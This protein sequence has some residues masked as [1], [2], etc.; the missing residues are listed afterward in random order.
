LANEP[1]REIAYAPALADARVEDGG[2]PSR[3]R[4]DKKQSV[5]LFD[6]SN[7]GVEEIGCPSPGRIERGTVLPAIEIG[8][9]EAGQQILE[10]KDLLHCGE[11]ADDRANALR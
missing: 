9:A 8:D 3:I 10:R 6:P 1:D 2:F 7:A 11:I 5:G 4:A